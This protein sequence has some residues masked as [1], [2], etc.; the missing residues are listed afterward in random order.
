MLNSLIFYFR[1]GV[2][3]FSQKFESTSG[4][5]FFFFLIA[6]SFTPVAELPCASCGVRSL[7]RLSCVRTY[8]HIC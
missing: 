2:E 7:A 4:F 5:F 3:E 6:L 1:T 8:S